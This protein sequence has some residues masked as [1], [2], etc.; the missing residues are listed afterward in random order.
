MPGV[1]VA[2]GG[3][4]PAVE[5][6]NRPKMP[7]LLAVKVGPPKEGGDPTGSDDSA[8]PPE[9]PAM[10]PDHAAPPDMGAAD[11][12]GAKLT[13]DIDSVFEGAG[14]DKAQG[15]QIAAQLFS[16]VAKCLGG[17]NEPAEHDAGGMDLEG[18]QEDYA[19]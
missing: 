6:R 7:P 8:A 9:K 19:K 2:L 13:A 1:I 10:A 14:I 4:D 17:D 3:K 12:Y 16:A 11:D 5:K 18:N 15:R